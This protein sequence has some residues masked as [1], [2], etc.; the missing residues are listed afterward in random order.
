MIVLKKSHGLNIIVVQ[1]V[2]EWAAALA[3]QYLYDKLCHPLS[4]N[5]NINV[6]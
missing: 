4:C 5:S 3:A 1:L 6:C 2:E